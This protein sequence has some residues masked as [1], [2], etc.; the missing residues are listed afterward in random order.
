M[1]LRMSHVTVTTLL[2][3][4]GFGT[5]SSD[6]WK[7]Q[8]QI[9]IPV[10]SFS[11]LLYCISSSLW[12]IPNSGCK[13]KHAVVLVKTLDPFSPEIALLKLAVNFIVV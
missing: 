13:C 6:L 7:S 8:L 2:F 1:L 5:A 11:T 10:S 12:E 4:P 3:V 9:Y